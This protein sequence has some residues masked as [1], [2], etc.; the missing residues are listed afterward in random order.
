MHF[1]QVRN[2]LRSRLKVVDITALINSH[3]R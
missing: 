2:Q 1:Q 3:I